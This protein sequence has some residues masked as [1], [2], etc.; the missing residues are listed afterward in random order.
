MIIN[1]NIVIRGDDQSDKTEY[2]AHVMFTGSKDK[3]LSV[4][5]NNVEFTKCGQTKFSARNCINF[6]K[7]GDASNSFITQN[8]IHRG[9]ARAIALYQTSYLTVT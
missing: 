5:I 1:R 4:N 7:V 9:Y 3:G 6:F 8:S 2:G